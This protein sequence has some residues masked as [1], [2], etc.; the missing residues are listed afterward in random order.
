[1]TESITTKFF[2][3][4]RHHYCSE[5]YVHKYY[6][7]LDLKREIRPADIKAVIN[8]VSQSDLVDPWSGIIPETMPEITIYYDDIKMEKIV[9]GQ[10]VR[11]VLLAYWNYKKD[12][13][14]E[15]S[16]EEE[17]AALKLNAYLISWEKPVQ[18]ECIRLTE[19]MDQRH[20]NNDAFLSDYEIELKIQ[21]YLRDDDAFS[22]KNNP[23]TSNDD[24]DMDAGLIC[25]TT[26]LDGKITRQQ[27]SDPNY[28]GIGDNQDHND[29]RHLG[30]CE[31]FSVRHCESFHELYDHLH[32]P[33]S[34]L[35]RIGRIWADILVCHQ[36]VVDIEVRG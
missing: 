19:E 18:Q 23:E 6:L 21:F 7:P 28:R 32:L 22:M 10:T 12:C 1:M 35:G 3:C 11:Q 31:L 27:A 5:R 15:L 2:Q 4:L 36:N 14:T 34:H 9:R 25:E 30:D 26:M 24:L 8:L 20:H 16:P 33:M 17:R 13:R 29:L